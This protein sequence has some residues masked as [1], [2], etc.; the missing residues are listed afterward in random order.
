MSFYFFLSCVLLI[1]NISIYRNVLTPPAL[2]VSVFEVGKGRATLIRT[3]HKKTVLI[4]TGS[5]ASIL[6]SLGETLSPFQRSIDTIILTGDSSA[7]TGGLAD[8]VGRYSVMRVRRIGTHD[9][10][11]GAPLSLEQD[12]SLMVISPGV[13][14]I[15]GVPLKSESP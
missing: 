2:D 9:L 7:M 4:D 3:P 14:L 13:Y 1:A 10:P 5:D 6:R 15:N 8:I 11:Y 12:T